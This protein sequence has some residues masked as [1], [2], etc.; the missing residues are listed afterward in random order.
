MAEYNSKLKRQVLLLAIFDHEE[1]II[2]IDVINMNMPINVRTLQRDIKELSEAGFLDVSYD[3]VRE[4]Y[5]GVVFTPEYLPELPPKQKRHF[6]NIKH[7][8]KILFEMDCLDERDIEKALDNLHYNEDIYEFWEEDDWQPPKYVDIGLERDLAAD[9]VY[10][11]MFPKAS[12]KDFDRD[13]KLLAE[14]GYPIEYDE[15]LNVYYKD[16]PEEVR[17]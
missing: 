1:A 6:E 5:D 2:D 8:E 15:E 16:F 7:F 10:F 9:K 4:R 17:A 12:R 13:L 14:I 3:R 11:R